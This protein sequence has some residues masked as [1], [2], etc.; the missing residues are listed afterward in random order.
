[1]KYGRDG[2]CEIAL[3]ALGKLEA[4]VVIVQLIMMVVDVMVLVA[5]KVTV[6]VNV[7]EFVAFLTAMKW[8]KWH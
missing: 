2:G 4:G 6:L 3:E 5:E 7:T 8:W 1:M